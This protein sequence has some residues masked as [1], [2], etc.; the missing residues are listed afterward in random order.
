METQICGI[1]RLDLE[2]SI[3]KMNCCTFTTHKACIDQWLIDHDTCPHCLRNA[4]SSN[5]SNCGIIKE[6]CLND[7]TIM[8]ICCILILFTIATPIFMITYSKYK[9]VYSIFKNVIISYYIDIYLFLFI[10]MIIAFCKFNS[11]WLNLIIS[12]LIILTSNYIVYWLYIVFNYTNRANFYRDKTDPN[13]KYRD[14]ISS[15]TVG[16]IPLSLFII[17]SFIISILPLI[18]KSIKYYSRN[19]QYSVIT[20]ESNVIQV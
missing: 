11:Y 18:E 17:I 9:D 2:G 7:T 4:V 3:V 10:F 14:F 1:C 13:M 16:I 6:I 15:I 19:N 20:T 12:E 5:C 8:F